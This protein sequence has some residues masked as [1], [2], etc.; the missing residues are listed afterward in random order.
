MGDWELHICVKGMCVCCWSLLLCPMT[1]LCRSGSATP[2]EAG[3]W[4]FGDRAGWWSAGPLACAR[5][6][7]PRLPEGMGSHAADG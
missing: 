2:G 4:A 6:G 1:C 3:G 5:D 7:V